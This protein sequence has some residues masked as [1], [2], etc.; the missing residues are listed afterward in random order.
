[1]KANYYED[2][3]LDC[4]ADLKNIKQTQKKL[5]NKIKLAKK[6]SDKVTSSNYTKLNKELQELQIKHFERFAKLII[7]LR[8][9]GGKTGFQ[10]RHLLSEFE[11]YKENKMK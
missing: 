8:N 11:T 9:I 6:E 1:M 2:L 3:I 10:K 4:L 5:I 7:E